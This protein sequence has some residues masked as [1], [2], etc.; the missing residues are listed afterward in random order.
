MSYTKPLSSRRQSRRRRTRTTL[1]L[2]SL[3]IGLT[4][5]FFP[6]KIEQTLGISNSQNTGI[7]RVL[8]V[9][10]LAHGFD[11]LTH[12]N[13]TPGLVARAAGDLLDSAVLAA[14][15]KKSRNPTGFLT[16]LALVTR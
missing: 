5:L 8:G 9:R 7:L 1:G 12:D 13:P 4:E 3:A 6:H 16:I 11:L 10:E 15:A 14:A 2:T